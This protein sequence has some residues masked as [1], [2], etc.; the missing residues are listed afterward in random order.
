MMSFLRKDAVVNKKPIHLHP[1]GLF[2]RLVLHFLLDILG[3][4]DELM[5]LGFLDSCYTLGASTFLDMF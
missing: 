1:G 4:L 5:N 2:F 3:L